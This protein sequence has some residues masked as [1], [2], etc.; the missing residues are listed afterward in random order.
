[1]LLNI[2]NKCNINNKHIYFAGLTWKFRFKNSPGKPLPRN[3]TIFC[4]KRSKR[5][6]N[7]SIPSPQKWRATGAMAL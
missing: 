7:A 6:G 3:Q 5:G 2:F 1:M 4:L